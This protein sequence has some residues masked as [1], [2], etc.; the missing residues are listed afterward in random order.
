MELTAPHEAAVVIV[1]EQRRIHDAEAGLF[2]LH[3]AAGLQRGGLLVRAQ[4]RQHRVPPLF[5]DDGHGERDHE[6]QG[7]GRTRS[8][9]PAGCSRPCAERIGE[10]GR[11]QEDRQHLQEVGEGRG[12]FVGMRGVGV[13]EA[14]AVRPQLLDGDLRRRRTD[15]QDL[16]GQRGFLRLR[17]A[18]RVQDG[19][20][21]RAGHRL[22]IGDRLHDRHLQVGAEG[23]HDA[24]GD[25]H[26]RQHER[27][28]QEDVQGAADEIHPEVADRLH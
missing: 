18:L 4:L 7:H 14:A 23:L 12:V 21:V 25:Q 20:A 10:P 2:A 22:V 3:V 17:L 28:R 16:L 27:N 15:R 24:L 8:P 13:E 9:N 19:L 26:Q 6:Q 5:G 1:R 11:D